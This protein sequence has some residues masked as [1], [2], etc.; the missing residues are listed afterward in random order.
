MTLPKTLAKLREDP[1]VEEISDERG[2]DAGYW[3]YFVPGWINTEADIHMI[4][5]DTV[6]EVLAVFRNYIE[7]C[8]CE[9]CEASKPKEA[10]I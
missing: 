9:S 1:R 3:I 5:E 7:P 4:H 10:A 2:E 8:D 6:K